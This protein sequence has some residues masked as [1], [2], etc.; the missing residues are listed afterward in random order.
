M[1]C[2]LISARNSVMEKKIKKFLSV[3]ERLKLVDEIKLG[4]PVKDVAT[5]FGVS[6]AQAY[7]VFKSKDDLHD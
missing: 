5:D 2:L 1:R 3:S 6:K 7:N 4:K